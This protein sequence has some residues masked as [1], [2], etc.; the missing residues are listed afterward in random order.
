MRVCERPDTSTEDLSDSDPLAA[1]I[2]LLAEIAVERH[3]V[4]G[5]AKRDR[6]GGVRRDHLASVSLSP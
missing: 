3:V 2:R 1:L 4:N 5:G 6:C